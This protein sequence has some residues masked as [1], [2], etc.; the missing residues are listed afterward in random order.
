MKPPRPDKRHRKIFVALFLLFAAVFFPSII[1]PSSPDHNVL[2]IHSYNPGFTWTDRINQSIQNRL[3][4]MNNPPEVFIEYMDMKRNEENELFPALYRLFESKYRDVDMDVIIVSDNYA[5]EFARTFCRDLFGDTPIVFCGINNFQD[6]MIEEDN[7][8]TGITENLPVA[9]TIELALRLNPGL[10]KM[11]VITNRQHQTGKAIY[12]DYLRQSR[13]YSKQIEFIHWDNIPL[14]TMARNLAL[15]DPETDATLVLNTRLK[16]IYGNSMDISAA[17]SYL[18]ARSSI[19]IYSLWED[20]MGLG[21][22]GGSMISGAEHGRVAGN[23]AVDILNGKEAFE[24]DIV[25]DGGVRTVI[26]YRQLNRFGFSESDVPSQARI[27]NR[28]ADFYTL[29]KMEVWAYIAVGLVILGALVFMVLANLARAR[30]QRELYRSQSR[31]VAL[32]DNAAAGIVTMDMEGTMKE[33]N[34]TISRMFG[35]SEKEMLQMNGLDLFLGGEWSLKAGT[36]QKLTRGEEKEIN[37]ERELPRRNGSTFWA[38]IALTAILDRKGE[39]DSFIAIITDLSERKRME[40]ALIRSENM[41]RSIIEQSMDGFVLVDDNFIVVEWNQGQEEIF[42]ISRI[43]ALGKYIWEV[44]APVIAESVTGDMV[45]DRITSDPESWSHRSLDFDILC[46]DGTMKYVQAQN[47]PINTDRGRYTGGI[48]RDITSRKTYE[49]TL[50]REKELLAFTLRSIAEGVITTDSEGKVTLINDRAATVLGISPEEARDQPL[51]KVLILYDQENKQYLDNLADTIRRQGYLFSEEGQLYLMSD[52]VGERIVSISASTILGED[53]ESLGLVL[54][55][56]DITEEVRLREGMERMQKLESLGV[57]AGGVAHDFNN[58]LAAI[59][60]NVSLVKQY[61]SEEN[62]ILEI[63]RDVEN[64]SI[65]ARNVTNQLLTFS[66]GGHPVKKP[67]D[68]GRLVRESVHFNLRGSALG[69]ELEI[70]DDLPSVEFDEAQIDQVLSNL[71]INA[72]EAMNDEGSL[73]VRVSTNEVREGDGVSLTPGLYVKVCVEDS[74]PGIDMDISS[75][76]FDPFFTTKKNG[77]GLGLASSYSIIQKHDGLLMVEPTDLGGVCLSF[78]LPARKEEGQAPVDSARNIRRGSGR[79]LYMDDDTM[80]LRFAR[81]SLEYMGYRVDFA[82]KGEEAL[83][84]Y[85]RALKEGDPYGCVVLDLTIPGGMGGRE[86]LSELNKIDPDVRAIVSSGY[87]NDPVMAQ[88]RENGFRGVVVK[89]Y[90]IEELSEAIHR[91][92][93]E[94]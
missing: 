2:V 70:E 5:F 88:Y 74:G 45:R 13:R 55:I 3:S 50:A 82:E 80:I 18:S 49:Q 11:I 91:V 59:L 22:L 39:F 86:T 85:K 41:F 77:S 9:R 31:L 75:R 25:R 40:R 35:Y 20:Y 28:A 30:A 32:F 83:Q 23:M 14:E 93:E 67:G 60:G 68:L 33:A 46:P 66:K 4:S 72:R 92:M 27:I 62:E 38:N 16:N 58:I 90:R 36:V 42:G 34:D 26:D 64:A 54:V 43:E 6:E 8:I 1:F 52:I 12:S 69:I 84:L 19:P 79:I 57:L 53:S 65:R 89:P 87:S 73:R 37:L 61:L 51:E 10:E 48:Y 29:G 81:K 78:L 44:M 17:S 56:N 21:I 7:H 76:I 94:K 63:I 24:I 47:F 71:V 15:M